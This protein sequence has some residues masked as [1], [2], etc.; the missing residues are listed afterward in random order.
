L[1]T[2]T[3][4]DKSSESSPINNKIIAKEDELHD[5]D[6]SKKSTKAVYDTSPRV[7]K[8]TIQGFTG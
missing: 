7:S 6:T 4:K 3:L 5:S 2:S 1:T 8:N